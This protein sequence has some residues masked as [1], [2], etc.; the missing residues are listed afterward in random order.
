MLSVD[1]IVPKLQLSPLYTSVYGTPRFPCAAPR[2]YTHLEVGRNKRVRVTAR[3]GVSGKHLPNCG[4]PRHYPSFPRA[5]S[6]IGPVTR[7]AARLDRIPA[8]R[9]GTRTSMRYDDSWTRLCITMRAEAWK[10]ARILNR[11]EPCVRNLL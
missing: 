2:I 8:Q 9:V 5:A 4:T 6:R 10:P 7:S 11:L 3:T 1:P